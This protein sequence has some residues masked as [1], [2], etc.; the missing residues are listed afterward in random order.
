VSTAEI[1]P[2]DHLVL[3]D[4]AECARCG[5]DTCEGCSAS[6]TG[7]VHAASRFRSAAE[8][9]RDP[10]PDAVVEGLLYRGRQTVLVAESGAGKSFAV[11]S[12][13]GAVVDPNVSRWAGREVITGSVALVL[14]ER[15]AV[16]LRLRALQ[17][18]DRD[19]ANLYVL[20]ASDTLS[21]TVTREGLELASPGELAVGADL[22]ALRVQLAS[23][24]RP[25]LVAVFFDTVRASMTGTEESSKDT[26][27]YLRAIDRIAKR[28]PGAAV[29]LVHHTG[30]QDGAESKKRER[31]S[32][33][34][35]GNVDVTA[36]L[37]VDGEQTDPAE[38]RLILRT[39]KNR[40]EERGAPLFLVRRRVVLNG[41]DAKGRT[42]TSCVIE[43]DTS[44]REGREADRASRAAEREVADG[45]AVLEVMAQHEVTAIKA[46]RS[47][48]RISKE[49]VDD[50]VRLVLTRK[51]AS[52]GARGKPY[53]VTPEGLK[54]LSGRRGLK[55]TEGDWSP[56]SPADKAK[57]TGDSLLGVPFP[58]S[59]SGTALDGAER[60]KGTGSRGLS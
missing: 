51:W 8:V 60:T 13:A 46:I 34:L 48:C 35:R 45:L 57:G 59:P 52:E 44:T 54:A 27:A 1:F 39:L 20:L 49:R 12:M 6:S 9:M 3:V 16:G 10:A 5:K 38:V 43:P 47:R 18:Q 30:W 2:F 26:S 28:A 42:V 33:A 31:G 36:M 56:V 24:G 22:D 29:G 55:G 50:A 14:F 15:D 25:E 40:D 53:T 21:P 58:E 23:A 7:V 17:E 41:Y 37:E 11:L 32:S 19:L 4:P